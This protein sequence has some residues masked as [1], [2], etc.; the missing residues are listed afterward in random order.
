LIYNFHIPKK[1]SSNGGKLW[2]ERDLKSAKTAEG[3]GSLPGKTCPSKIPFGRIREEPLY[4]RGGKTIL[5]SR[6]G[7]HIQLCREKHSG[8]GEASCGSGGSRGKVAGKNR[9]GG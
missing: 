9:A 2:G 1:K 6:G 7:E 3:E 5:V 4:D 8:F